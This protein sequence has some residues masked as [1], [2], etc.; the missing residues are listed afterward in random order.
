MNVG[1]LWE[2]L[3]DCI[4]RPPR[5]SYTTA[6][7]I[8][9]ESRRFAI[10]KQKGIRVDVDLVNKDGQ[11][12]KCSHF[13][14]HVKG[15]P[16]G[17]QPCVVYCHCNSG[18]RRDAEEAVILLVPQKISVFTLDFSGSGRSDGD[19]VTLGARETD[20]LQVAIEYL[21]DQGKTSTI[22]LWGRSMGAVTAIMYSRRDPSI[23]GMVLDSPFS[24][25]TDLMIELV[26]DQ[27]VP[28]PRALVKV[29]LAAMRRSVRKRAGIDITQVAPIDIVQ[30]SFVPVL[31]GHGSGDT[32]VKK[33]HSEKLYEKYSGDK[34]FITFEGDHNSRRPQF[35]YSSASIFY[36]TVLQLNSDPVDTEASSASHSS[37]PGLDRLRQNR[38]GPGATN[39]PWGTP[40][41]GNRPSAKDLTNMLLQE[42]GAGYDEADL[43]ADFAGGPHPSLTPSVESLLRQPHAAP[44]LEVEGSSAEETWDGVLQGQQNPVT[45]RLSSEWRLLTPEDEATEVAMLEAA[46]EAS[47]TDQQRQQ[48]ETAASTPA[49]ARSFYDRPRAHGKDQKY[50]QQRS[51][52][53]RGVGHDEARSPE[54]RKSTALSP[55]HAS[56]ASG[57][58]GMMH[59]GQRSLL[60]MPADD[61]LDRDTKSASKSRWRR[62]K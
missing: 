9:G 7:L 58:M 53:A 10:G 51:R 16:E 41:K 23:A 59:S 17:P 39:V 61:E 57:H 47:L 50:R 28:I 2:Q 54:P 37:I 34:N 32:F 25:L 30:E 5:D 46:V 62:K 40:W 42:R 48:M 21:R 26:Q 38:E 43:S 1:Q 27:Q 45:M 20:D 55:E 18:S 12:L 29:A 36:H 19:W 4:C 8:G 15:S 11:T 3:V 60:P 22:A 33:A 44:A 49:P 14:P 24:K 35:F 6:D 31:F 52:A 56:S 13:K